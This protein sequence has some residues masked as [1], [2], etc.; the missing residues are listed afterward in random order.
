M[1]MIRTSSCPLRARARTSCTSSRRCTRIYIYIYIYI[2]VCR[3]IYIY[4]HIVAFTYSMYL[5]LYQFVHIKLY[6]TLCT[7]SRRCTRSAEPRRKASAINTYIRI[8]IYIYIY[9]HTYIHNYVVACTYSV[10]L[11][12]YQFISIKLYNCH[13][14]MY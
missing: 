6:V 12:L 4:T 13:L 8:H 9:T 14:F 10:Y 11:L 7:S 1:I 5:L 3:Y 2:C